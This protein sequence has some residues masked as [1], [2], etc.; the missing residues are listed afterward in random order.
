[1]L[2]HNMEER[3]ETKFS[4]RD[5]KVAARGRKVEG[6]S[7]RGPYQPSDTF[8]FGTN[9][10]EAGTLGGTTDRFPW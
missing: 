8:S 6:Q 4:T 10:G 9:G 1:M 3:L 2:D 5:T 7:V